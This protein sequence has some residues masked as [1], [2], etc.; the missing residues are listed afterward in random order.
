[1]VKRFQKIDKSKCVHPPFDKDRHRQ[2]QDYLIGFWNT[3]L[4]G[5]VGFCETS[6]SQLIIMLEV[7]KRK[8]KDSKD[9]SSLHFIRFGQWDKEYNENNF[10]Q[11]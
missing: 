2:N 9:G 3:L 11:Y 7:Y 4:R 5:N 10:S 6:K 8:Y 1:M